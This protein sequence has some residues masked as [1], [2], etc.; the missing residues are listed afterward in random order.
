MAIAIRFKCGHEGLISDSVN[1][2]PICHCG[3]TQIT[4]VK[5]SRPPRFT[6]ACTGPYATHSHADPAVV[7]VAPAGPLRVKETA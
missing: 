5:P 4:F 1:M 7:N 3:E 6:G 2:S